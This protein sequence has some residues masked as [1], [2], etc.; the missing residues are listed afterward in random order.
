MA[1]VI[2]SASS[3]IVSG[4]ETGGYLAILNSLNNGLV[5]NQIVSVEIDTLQNIEFSDHSSCHMA[6]LTNSMTHDPA[7]SISDLSWC[8]TKLHPVLHITKIRTA[9][10]VRWRVL[11]CMDLSLVSPQGTYDL[12][13]RRNWT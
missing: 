11:I 6:V 13:S 3:P 5:S 12:I 8:S 2:F 9:C 10:V 7:A 4:P 1:F